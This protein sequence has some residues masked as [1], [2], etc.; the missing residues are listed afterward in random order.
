VLGKRASDDRADF[1]ANVQE[2]VRKFIFKNNPYPVKPDWR[3][4]GI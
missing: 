4:R 1:D 3:A 2:Q